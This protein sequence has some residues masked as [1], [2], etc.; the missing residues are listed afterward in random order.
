MIELSFIL[1]VAAILFCIA[2]IFN[3]DI[4]ELLELPCLIILILLFIYETH[5]SKK[6]TA[7]DVYQ[8]MTELKFT[9]INGEVVDSTVIFKKNDL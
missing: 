7:M 2:S 9:V 3:D 1:I 5:K 8:G 6:P 4:H